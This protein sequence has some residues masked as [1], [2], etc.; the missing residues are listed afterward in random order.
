MPPGPIPPTPHRPGRRHDTFS[1]T[2]LRVFRNC[3]EQ[4]YRTYLGKERVPA[5]FSA[6]TLRGSAVHKV[7]ATVFQ[8]RQDGDIVDHDLHAL[9][10]RFLPIRLYRRAGMTSDWEPDVK[11]VVGLAMAG[12]RRVPDDAKV[13]SVEKSFSTV[14]SSRSPVAGTTLVGK[15]DLVILHRAGF[16]EQIEFKTG[17]AL[18][19]PLQE[20]ICRMGVCGVYNASQVP[21]LSTTV[22]LS[23]GIDYPLDNDRDQLA[24]VLGE[25]ERTILEIWE[26]TDWPAQ[27]NDRCRFCNYRVLL[28]SRFGDRSHPNRLSER[29]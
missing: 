15:V 18:P 27:E 26:T 29:D 22:Q 12:L 19:D 13:L 2:Q 25:I 10:E 16:I 28:C 11:T 6:A 1:P 21:V 8:S 23:S 3:P 7:L 5:E 17:G 24:R 9:A 14:L 4:Y 20:V